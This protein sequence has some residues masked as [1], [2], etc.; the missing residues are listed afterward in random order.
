MTRKIFRTGAKVA[1]KG[2][3]PT[4]ASHMRA[5]ALKIERLSHRVD[6]LE[7]VCD[8]SKITA[9]MEILAEVEINDSKE[10]QFDER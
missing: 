2:G 8:L 10:G 3:N 9:D 4:A 7:R 6:G 1:E 5:A